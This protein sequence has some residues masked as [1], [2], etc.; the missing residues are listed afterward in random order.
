MAAWWE[1]LKPTTITL[2]DREWSQLEQAL[3]AEPVPNENLRRAAQHLKA[4]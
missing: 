1:R 2:T 3:A 4:L